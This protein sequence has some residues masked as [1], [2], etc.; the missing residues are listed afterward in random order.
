MTVKFNAHFLTNFS[1][2]LDKNEVVACQESMSVACALGGAKDDDDDD[3][4]AVCVPSRAKGDD[5]DDEMV[6]CQESTY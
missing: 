1:I 3:V 4:S 2:D 5:G 6:A